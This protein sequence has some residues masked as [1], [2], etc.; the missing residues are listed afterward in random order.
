MP[1]SQQLPPLPN[2]NFASDD[3]DD[4]EDEK[5]DDDEAT[6]TTATTT[7]GTGTASRL[8]IPTATTASSPSPS[9]TFQSSSMLP[10]SSA[11]PSP[12]FISQ[13]KRRV[14][15]VAKQLPV[16]TT[17]TAAGQWTCQ[18]EDTRNFL[19]ALAV[20]HTHDQI[21]VKWVGCPNTDTPVLLEQQ[22]E[23]ED[24]LFDYDCIPVFVQPS[25]YD[26]FFHGF[27][28]SVLWPLFHYVMPKSNEHFG[29]MW[30]D[31]WQ[32]YT[33]ANSL[34][35]SVVTHAVETPTDM[36]WIQNYH[37]LLLPS[38]LRTKLPRAKIGLFIHTPFPSSDVFR[39]LPT[40][41]NI[42]SSMLATDLIGFHTF[43]YARHFLSCIKRVMDLDFETMAGGALG[44]KYNGRY[45]SILISHVGID[46]RKFKED[47]ESQQVEG[48]RR[49]IEETTGAGSGGSGGSGGR[50]LILSVDDYDVVKGVIMKV[51]AFRH[52]LAT[53]P[54]WRDKVRIVQLLHSAGGKDESDM[55]E[56]VLG[57]I[58]AINA[59]YNNPITVVDRDLSM[60]D[61]VA[62]YSTASVCVVSTF[63]DGLNLTPYEFSASQLHDRP[64]ALIISE[65]MGCSRSLNGVIR[66]NPWS[67]VQMTDAIVSA[68]S[69]TDDERRVHHARRFNYVMNH[70]IQ[71]WGLSYLE[72]LDKA[73]KF[74]SSLSYVQVGWGSNV[75][76]MGL[77]SDFAH[78]EEDAITVAYRK[79]NTRVLLLDYDGT[80]TPLEKSSERSALMHPTAEIKK[81]LRALCEDDRN[82]VFIMSGRTRS[83]L[84][85]WFEDLPQLG[86]A[87][88][89]G[90]FLRWP[91][92]L[93]SSHRMDDW[94]AEDS[95]LEREEADK[96]R[97]E[98]EAVGG[99]SLTNLSPSNKA[100]S[101][102]SPTTAAS[103]S[104]LL[105][106]DD[107]L[108][109]V[110]KNDWES[111]ISLDDTAWKDTALSL[112]ASY[113]EQ[114]DGSWIEPKEHAIVWHY[115]NADPEYG[116]MQA[117]ELQKYLIKLLGNPSVDVVKYDYARVLEVKPH[118][119]SKGLAANAILESYL[120]RAK[121]QRELSHASLASLDRESTGGSLSPIGMSGGRGSSSFSGNVDELPVVSAAS[122]T[123]SVSRPTSPQASPGLAAFEFATDPFLLCVGDDRSDED[124]FVAVN[125]KEYLKMTGSEA[126]LRRSWSRRQ[127]DQADGVSGDGGTGT[128]P[129]GALDEGKW[130]DAELIRS[131][132]PPS[133]FTFTV[134]VGMKPSNAH[135][136]LHDD[137]E[138]LKTLHSLATC[139][140]RMQQSRMM[141]RNNS[142][143]ALFPLQRT[144]S[145]PGTQLTGSQ[146]NIV[147]LAN[148]NSLSLA[149][150]QREV[151]AATARGIAVA[152]MNANSLRASGSRGGSMM[153]LNG[154]KGL[155]ERKVSE[156]DEDNEDDE[157][158]DEYE[159]GSGDEDGE[160][161]DV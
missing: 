83:V 119:I 36:I 98:R 52:F 73:T 50:Q 89:K 32:A 30:D 123:V 114:T 118:G 46:S 44:V 122:A 103:H 84:T 127:A 99:D 49:Q 1:P 92:R 12:A 100:E 142:M 33:A 47:S 157:S 60:L 128:V 82:C 101:I 133:P 48:Q 39:V 141:Q 66:V 17:R 102:T 71:R 24:L 6:N 76:L 121:V 120:L 156:E 88:E 144:V 135:Y 63:W 143:N 97:R 136:Y 96:K 65:F 41:H 56:R 147:A 134:C 112:I 159:Y 67:L 78:L 7:T 105:S 13:K 146:V 108:S 148:V 117:S 140:E 158:G 145:L 15:I 160:T 53:H 116:R 139:S 74:Q 11:L 155:N 18:W 151:L 109:T 38:F 154:A 132:N 137:E 26:R 104:H 94:Q 113:T 40:R 131:R 25:L 61:M 43:D 51:L 54:E 106:T 35:A 72:Q 149:S 85:A 64:G 68:L 22:E 27:C 45:V 14:V 110:I 23:Y 29:E 126:T 37:L 81:I 10:A 59:E 86:L 87:A 62:Y 9:V 55:R 58:A 31:H 95:R 3:E 161:I 69:M 153:G 80:L 111:L 107:S 115:E 5:D 20:L 152:A 77:R 21:D 138:V 79:A 125:T 130:S 28:K 34:Y 19:S 57:E 42:L 75:K 150:G 2:P 129:A 4:E 124:M 91:A 16:R 70:S 93:M 90:L 8:T